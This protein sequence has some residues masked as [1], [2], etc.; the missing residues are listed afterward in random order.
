MNKKSLIC[1][2]VQASL[3][4][5]GMQLRECRLKPRHS[6]FERLMKNSESADNDTSQGLNLHTARRAD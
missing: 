2:P 3:P 4:L 1:A 5:K 6:S